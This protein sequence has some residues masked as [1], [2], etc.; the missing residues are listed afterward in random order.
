MV[1][2]HSARRFTSIH[3]RVFNILFLICAGGS[4]L[5]GPTFA[6]VADGTGAAQTS[7]HI[8]LAPK[9]CFVPDVEV[10]AKGVLHMVYALNRLAYYARS[11]D[12]GVTFSQP[13]QVNSEGTVEFKMGERG[14]KLA[15]GG[16]GVIHVVWVDCSAPA[17]PPLSDMRA[18]TMAGRSF[19]PL[20]TVSSMNGVDG[21]TMTA[22]GAGHVFVFWHVAHP[23]QS[24]IP[25]AT[26]LH[27]ARSSDN[28]ITFARGRARRRSQITA[29]WPVRCVWCVRGW[30]RMAASILAFRSAERNIRDFYVLKGSPDNNKFTAIRVNEDNWELKTC[31]MCG[32]ELTL[33]PREA[34]NY[35]PS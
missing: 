11:T 17:W 35:A 12:N 6:A 21:V 29:D 4:A 32:P 1:L 28:G 7:V 9:D 5:L 3:R 19:E 33:K 22:D 14:P 16:D 8:V 27:L 34:D 30:V 26:W 18:V 13:V 10:D 15:V 20:Q 25:Q 31:P 24:D 23:P 2:Q